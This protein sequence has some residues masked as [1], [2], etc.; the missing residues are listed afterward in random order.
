[1][2]S[3]DCRVC[4]VFPKKI[5][6]V[7]PF[8]H[9]SFN[10]CVPF[11][12]TIVVGVHGAKKKI[13]TRNSK[14]L[15]SV[16]HT[17]S[18]VY[19]RVCRQNKKFPCFSTAYKQLPKHPPKHGLPAN[20]AIDRWPWLSCVSVLEALVPCTLVR[21]CLCKTC[22]VLDGLAAATHQNARSHDVF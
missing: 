21:P 6:K 8:I 9:S 4:N 18:G 14:A 22:C 2:R 11:S 17:R 1:M 16:F 7:Q 10:I 3:C 13:R 20:C 19:V 12:S 15:S 5:L